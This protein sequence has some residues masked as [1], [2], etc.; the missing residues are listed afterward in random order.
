MS[1]KTKKYLEKQEKPPEKVSAAKIEIKYFH[2]HEQKKVRK[3]TGRSTKCVTKAVDCL[4][5][6]KESNILEKNEE[7]YFS[8]LNFQRSVIDVCK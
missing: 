2:E 1:S 4:T 7:K 3:R 5:R 8:L 6:G